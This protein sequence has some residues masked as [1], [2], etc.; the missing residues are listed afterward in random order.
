MTAGPTP[1][2]SAMKIVRDPSEAKTGGRPMIM[3][4]GFFDG[5]HR[6]HQAVINAARTRA[7]EINGQAWVLTFDPHPMKVLQPQHAPAML[8]RTPHKLRILEAVGLDGCVV[9]PFTHELAALPAGDFLALLHR[10]L[11][12]L[13]HIV[14]GANW[15]FGRN[16]EGSVRLLQDLADEYRLGVTEVPPLTWNGGVI[17][18]TRIRQA[19]RNG[20]LDDAAA[21]LGRPYSIWGPVVHGWQIGRLLGFPTANINPHNEVHPPDGVY[22]ARAV[23]EGKGY[24]AAAY[25]G[26]A[27][28]FH[29]PARDWVAEVYLLDEN[30]DLYDRNVEVF[31]LER[32][33]PDR[34]F[35]SPQ[36]LAARIAQDI[37]A[38][39][40]ICRTASD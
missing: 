34:R 32:I 24:D 27:P 7:A 40:R 33:R 5:V 28:T 13:K 4:V 8:T 9:M 38:A 20:A 6:G 11:R 17:S 18:S 19:V 26:R 35:D 29:M 36:E 39:R 10:S 15:A 3:A 22:A 31:F 2:N 25:I 1:E 16:R 14:V 30:V 23:V 21:M 37:E 12:S